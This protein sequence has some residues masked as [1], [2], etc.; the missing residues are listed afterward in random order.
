MN[1][2]RTLTLGSIDRNYLETAQ[3]L[4]G[5]PYRNFIE[6]IDFET[7][8]FGF[9]EITTENAIYLG[10]KAFI[11]VLMRCN[12][13]L[14]HDVIKYLRNKLDISKKLIQDE[15]VVECY[16]R[17]IAASRCDDLVDSADFT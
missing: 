14:Y 17:V 4:E 6:A 13:P 15:K 9:C 7:K 2:G 11:R 10:I 12:Y 16:D 1:K 5:N 3:D 8:T